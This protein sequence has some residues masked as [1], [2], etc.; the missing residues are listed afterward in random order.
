M[1][2]YS[3]Y[4]GAALLC[5]GGGGAD[6]ASYSVSITDRSMTGAPI[7]SNR[8]ADDPYSATACGGGA[9][10]NVLNAGWIPYTSDPLSD[11]GGL[12][13]RL[14]TEGC[15]P[16]VIALVDAVPGSNGLEF[17]DPSDGNILRDGNDPD[18]IFPDV[19]NATIAFAADP[20]T[21]YRPL[22]GDYFVTYQQSPAG[23]GRRTTISR[24][25]TPSDHN[26]WHRHDTTMFSTD[27]CATALWFP[28][29]FDE[30]ADP[31]DP[32]KEYAIAT[33]GE[34]R[35]GNL[36][37]V[38]SSDHMKTWDV[39]ETFVLTRNDSYWDNATLSTGPSPVMLSDG[40]WLLL[41]NIDNLWPVNDPVQPFPY[42][43]RCA[44]GYVILDANN[45]TNVLARS[46]EPLVYAEL[47]WELNGT[48]PQ[49][50][51]TDGIRPLGGDEFIVY[52]GGGD[53]VIE[54]LSIKI[55]INNE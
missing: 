26:S 19:D 22:T 52:S 37:L 29:D 5:R 30:S 18:A 48:T 9:C 42:F 14:S 15:Y 35:G 41:Y 33:F 34:L 6:A 16:S 51:Y 2:F 25:K 31:N 24:S 47:P 17:E 27:D 39:E 54:A 49:V 53:T 7:I 50:V 23:G 28:Y 36:T 40:N 21:A 45:I 13:L 1:K 8:P 4:F 55:N 43:G 3:V 44:L 20:R 32:P 46:D 12:F 11:V 38:S 10:T